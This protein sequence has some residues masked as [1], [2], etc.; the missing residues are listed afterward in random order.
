[1]VE[2]AGADWFAGLRP[3]KI[4][5]DPES[6]GRTAAEDDDG[7][8]FHAFLAKTEYVLKRVRRCI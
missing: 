7:S 3:V 2:S 6:H 4:E 5:M 1:M 8:S